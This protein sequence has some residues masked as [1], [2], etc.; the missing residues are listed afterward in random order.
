MPV[1]STTYGPAPR[2]VE[3]GDGFFDPVEAAALHS[4]EDG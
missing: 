1:F 2:I 3:L 4:G